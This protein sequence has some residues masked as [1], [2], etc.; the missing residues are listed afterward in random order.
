MLFLLRR[1]SVQFIIA[2][3]FKPSLST[4]FHH[5][6]FHFITCFT[7]QL[8]SESV[9]FCIFS[10]LFS[11]F[12]GATRVTRG[13]RGNK[14]SPNPPNPPIPPTPPTSPTL[15]IPPPILRFPQFVPILHHHDPVSTPTPMSVGGGGK[16]GLQ[17][18]YWGRRKSQK[19]QK[20]Q[21]ENLSPILRPPGGLRLPTS[22]PLSID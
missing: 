12:F 16:A 4:S 17:M 13:T 1:L 10:S 22:S 18:K 21:V 9:L 3:S 8:D 7:S 2:F 20:V 19:S 5:Y 15:P 14:R 6:P 11:S